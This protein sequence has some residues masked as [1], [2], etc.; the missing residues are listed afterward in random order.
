MRRGGE[1]RDCSGVFTEYKMLF[2]AWDSFWNML[3]V[4]S[5]IFLVRLD[6]GHQ[7]WTGIWMDTWLFE[8][9]EEIVDHDSMGKG[10]DR[11]EIRSSIHMSL[12]TI[13]SPYDIESTQRHR[14]DWKLI[15][16]DRAHYYIYIYKCIMRIGALYDRTTFSI[17]PNRVNISRRNQEHNSKL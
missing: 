5:L 15:I 17:K 9:V 8:I 1:G 12:S 11:V 7:I 10:R 2:H 14:M 6:S 13:Q 3:S 4:W 16:K